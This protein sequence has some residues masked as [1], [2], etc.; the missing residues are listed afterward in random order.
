MADIQDNQFWPRAIALVDMNA[1]F[2]AIEQHDNPALYGRPVAITNGLTGT[3]VITCS[4]EAR[5]YGVYTGI[6]IREAR[7]L[8]PG[9][10]QRPANPVR[11]ARVSTHI[12]T[13][14]RG[15]SPDMEVF[16]VDEA[17]L[18]VTRCQQL[19]GHP[20]RI[21]RLI[22]ETVFRVSGLRC[23]VGM[24]GD[25]TTAKYAAKLQKP[26]GLTLIPP[27]QA[28]D[29][30][31]DVPVTELCG[32]N[33]GI[34]AFLAR[35]GVVT[36]G[37]MAG[38]P[39]GV[40]GQRFGNPGRR[41]WYMCRGED[42][43]KVQD[44]TAAPKSIGHGKVMPPD[45]RD[46]DLIY[47]YLIHMAEKVAARLRRHAMQAQKYFIGMRS[48][49]GWLGNKSRTH[50]PTNDSRP[51]IRLCKTAMQR[52]WQGQG[53]FQVHVV[54][55]DPRPVGGQI[56]I[57][58]EEDTRALELNRA[59]DLINERFGEFAIAPARLLNRS[60]MPNVIAPAWKPYGHRQTIPETQ[61]GSDPDGTMA[62]HD[63]DDV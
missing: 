5:A 28:R 52:H 19:W 10:V 37:D 34:G 43:D 14:L 47:M 27:W 46:R 61:P 30:L 44:D 18:D 12:M 36:C 60:D 4:Y 29:R 8:C 24:S 25:K 63:L 62:I 2:A 7:Q 33:T 40:L 23:S 55:L 35:R 59:L 58:S 49:D 15:I 51:L 42:P 54:A 48:R 9:L 38:L 20:E 26:D 11:Y 53:V 6:R 45:T 1:F 21:A 22:K 31:R 57:F 13:A 50:I 41:I 17:F 32:I 16:S 3:C 39:I 56:D